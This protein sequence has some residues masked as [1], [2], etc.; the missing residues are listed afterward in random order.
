VTS[1][2]GVIVVQA[3]DDVK[4]EEAAQLGQFRVDRP[5][6]L[7]LELCFDLA[8]ETVAGEYVCQLVIELLNTHLRRAPMARARQH[9]REKDTE[10]P[11]YALRTPQRHITPSLFR[12]V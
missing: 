4:P 5:A 9:N 10:G 2:A 1:G 6:Q 7:G 12:M 3:A 11:A 8:S